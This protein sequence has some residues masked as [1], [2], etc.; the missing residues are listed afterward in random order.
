MYMIGSTKKKDRELEFEFAF[1]FLIF[2]LH[3]FTRSA[4]AQKNKMQ[5]QKHTSFSTN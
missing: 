2:Y 5:Q 1:K 4:L 3:E